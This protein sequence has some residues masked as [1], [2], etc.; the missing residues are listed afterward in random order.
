[1]ISYKA[2]EERTPDN[3]YKQALRLTTTGTYTKNPYQE[4]GTYTVVTLPNM[5]FPLANGFPLITE[6]EIPF[7]RKPISEIIAFINGARTLAEMREYGD[8][9]TWASWWGRWANKEKCAKF[10]LA[11]GDLGPGSYGAAYHDFPLPSGETFNQWEHL[12]R[13]IRERP[14]LRTHRVTTWIPYYSLQHSGLQRRVVVAPCHGDIQVTILDGRMFLRMDQRSGDMPIG[15]P[16]N[17]IQHA[18]VLLMLAQVT[19][20]EAH[21]YIH[22]VHDAQIYEDQLHHVERL[23]EREDRPFPTLRIT[24]PSIDDIFAFRPEHFELTDYHPHPAMNDI[25]VTE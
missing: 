18:A 7:W 1:V 3:Q 10:G 9:K 13:Q 2:F 20:Y 4:R 8:Q 12:V 11:P 24:D 5:V 15:V 19:G 22:S 21:T 6:R 23:L 16:S 17:M 25:P 14:S